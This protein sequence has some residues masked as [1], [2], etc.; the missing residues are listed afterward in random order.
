MEYKN[1]MVLVMISTEFVF[2]PSFATASTICNRF[3]AEIYE[4]L[5]Q[6]YTK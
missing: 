4:Y 1:E 6:K 5:S 3:L 2:N